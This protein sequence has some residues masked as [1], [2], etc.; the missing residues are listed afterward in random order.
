MSDQVTGGV[1][2]DPELTR[3][4]DAMVASASMMNWASAMAIFMPDI[5]LTRGSRRVNPAIR[6]TSGPAS[7]S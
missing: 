4:C 7:P 1:G 2:T 3:M 5:T 6:S